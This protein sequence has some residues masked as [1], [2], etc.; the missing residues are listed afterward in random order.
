MEDI[1]VAPQS[2]YVEILGRSKLLP[3]RSVCKMDI[4]EKANS[5]LTSSY[6]KGDCYKMAVAS[7]NQIISF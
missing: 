4:K 6:E 5:V 1:S 2:F 7:L 3:Q